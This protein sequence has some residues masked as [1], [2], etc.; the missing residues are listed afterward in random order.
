VKTLVVFL[1]LVL[2]ILVVNNVSAQM[3][4][5]TTKFI[6]IIAFDE[7]NKPSHLS[8]LHIAP[9]LLPGTDEECP[10]E[11]VIAK[12]M[13]ID[14][15]NNTIR[16]MPLAIE[17]GALSNPVNVLTDEEVTLFMEKGIVN[18]PK[19]D[20]KPAPIVPKKG[21]LTANAKAEALHSS[22]N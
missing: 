14:R 7:N 8:A 22:T 10:N 15:K 21:Q 9:G 13:E 3:C 5:S 12:M 19:Q 11:N 16:P 20:S 2:S 1:L 6:R 18:P 17:K 4:P